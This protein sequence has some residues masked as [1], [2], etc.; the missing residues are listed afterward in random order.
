MAWLSFWFNLSSEQTFCL[1]SFTDFQSI[2][3]FPNLHTSPVVRRLPSSTLLVF[4]SKNQLLWA[5]PN[6]RLLVF[7][8]HWF[9]K[10]RL[11]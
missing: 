6:H 7:N 8:V 10:S 3:F 11:Q 9:T 2:L 1:A 4:Y 5:F